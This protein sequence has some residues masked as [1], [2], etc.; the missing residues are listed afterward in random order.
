MTRKELNEPYRLQREIKRDQERLREIEERAKSCGA[1]LSG[2]PPGGRVSDKVGNGAMDIV[3][4]KKQISEKIT[5]KD[6]VSII[7]WNQI[8]MIGDSITRDILKMRH[9][10]FLSFKQIAAKLGGNN[11]EEGVKMRYY[12]AMKNIG[13]IK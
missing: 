5:E 3:A 7:L 12:R 8:E 1:P 11:T 4:M 9:L 2:L 6:K 13:A 10:D